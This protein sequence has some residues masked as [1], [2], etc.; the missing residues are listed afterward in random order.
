MCKNPYIFWVRW[1][2]RVSRKRYQFPSPDDD[3]G[4][5]AA[6]LNGPD[7]NVFAFDFLNTAP[8][9]SPVCARGG[10]LL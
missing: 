9:T 3:R 6:A 7:N 8:D 4:I 5:A 2:P 1:S 10:F